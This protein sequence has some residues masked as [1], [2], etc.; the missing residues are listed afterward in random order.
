M[1][2]RQHGH[3]LIEYTVLFALG[4]LVLVLGEDSPLEQLVR[5]IQVAYGRFTYALS[6]P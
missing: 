3:S 4:G 2:H 5:G 6:L 1:K